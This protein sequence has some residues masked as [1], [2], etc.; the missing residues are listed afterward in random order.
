MAGLAILLV[1]RL[2]FGQTLLDI[3][4]GL[5]VLAGIARLRVVLAVLDRNAEAFD[6]GGDVSQFLGIGQ[7]SGKRVHRRDVAQTGTDVRHLLDQNRGVLTGE[8]R[9]G[10]VGTTSA[11]WQVAGAAGFVTFF[12]ALLVTLLGQGLDLLAVLGVPLV[13]LALDAFLFRCRRRSIGD[14]QRKDRQRRGD[15]QLL[16]QT[17]PRLVIN[18]AVLS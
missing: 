9:E 15:N 1:H 5:P 14:A 3:G 16:H 10:T 4:R 2:A 18:H 8:L 6:V 11:G 12:A 13:V 7:R 17:T